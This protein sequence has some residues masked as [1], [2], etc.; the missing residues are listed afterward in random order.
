[1]QQADKEWKSI[2]LLQTTTAF[3]EEKQVSEAR[4]SAELLLCHVLKA[5]RLQLYLQHSRPVYPD[6]LDAYRALCRKRLQGW[7]V[8]YLTGEQYF[9]GRVFKVDSRV[10]IPRP[11]TELVVEHAIER[12]RRCVREGSQ[13]SILD[14]GTG[15]GCI[16]VTAALQLPGARITAIDCSADALDVARENARCYGV[17]TRIRFLQADMLAPEF[18]EDDEAAFDLI[19]ANPPYIPDSE[20]DDLQAE[21][22]EYE[23]RVALTTAS[24]LECY[25]AVAARAPSLLCQSGILCFEL[26]ADG[27]GAVSVLM[28]ESGFGDILLH[29]DYGGYDRILS[30]IRGGL[31]KGAL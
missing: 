17:E 24:G 4:L 13:L 31:Q 18:L 21:V 1:M 14:I 25:R 12:L 20:W 8:Q 10:L 16:A 15:S 23:P 11:E 22:R 29:K 19:I 28:K 7:P 3:F 6:E 26:H 27:A 2:E 5:N 9:Y 30:A